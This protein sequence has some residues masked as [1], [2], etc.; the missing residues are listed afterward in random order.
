MKHLG[1]T[2]VGLSFL[3]LL[4]AY[5]SSIGVILALAVL[6]LAGVSALTGVL[7]YSVIVGLI[8]TVNVF[9]LSIFPLTLKSGEWEAMY[10]PLVFYAIYSVLLVAGL[11]VKTRAHQRHQN[12]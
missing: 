11:Y 12:I 7:R 6:V 1:R 10:V 2:A 8:T 3:S 4:P 9:G 5:A